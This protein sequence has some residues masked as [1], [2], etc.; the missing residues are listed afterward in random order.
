MARRILIM[1][2]AGRD[3]HNFNTV[4]RGKS[5]YN[6]VAFTAAQIPDIAGRRYPAKLAGKGYPKG[7]PIHAEAGP[8]ET[9]RRFESRRSCLR[10]FRCPAHI[11][12]ASGL[13]CARGRT[14]F[15]AARPQRHDDQVDQAGHLGLRG[16][17][18]RGQVADDA[19]CLPVAQRAR[20]EGGRDSSPHAVRRSDQADFAALR[21]DV[22]PRQVQM[23][24]R[25]ARGV[26]A[27]HHDRH[28]DLRRRRLRRHSE[29]GREGSGCHRL[30]WRQQ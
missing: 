6:V 18:R 17:H 1:G 4:Y 23:H 11:R 14:G 3:F 20:Q 10:L 21:R 5:A 27:A 9:H 15:H 28:R 24:D 8:R 30:G 29:P 22:R 7:I 25:R 26:R 16:P 2:A 13:A 19:P 12:H